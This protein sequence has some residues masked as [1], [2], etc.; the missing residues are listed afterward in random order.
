MAPAANTAIPSGAN[1]VTTVHGTNRSTVCGQPPQQRQAAAPRQQSRQQWAQSQQPE[2]PHHAP[3]QGSVSLVGTWSAGA[4]PN[5]FAFAFNPDGTYVNVANVNGL[6]QRLWGHYRAM[7]VSPTSVRLDF[8][9]VG[10][11]PRAMCAQVVGGARACRPYTPIYSRSAS[12]NFT[13]PSSFEAGGSQ[14]RRDPSPYLLQMQVPDV[15]ERQVAGMGGIR[16]PVMP[17]LH[18]YRT[19][20]GAGSVEAMR[21]DD[22]HQQPYRICAVNDGSV[23]TDQNGVQHCTN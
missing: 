1:C 5:G 12:L 3:Q 15:L 17:A 14:F 8:Q 13:S 11:A 20:G 6:S 2:Q 21:H 10:W 4:P 23:Y 22:E 18:P 9:V 16:Q 19:P 7:P